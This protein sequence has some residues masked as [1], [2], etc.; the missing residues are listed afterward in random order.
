MFCTSRKLTKIANMDSVEFSLISGF[1]IALLLI[2]LILSNI[3]KIEETFHIPKYEEVKEV[4]MT[5][6]CLFPVKLDKPELRETRPGTILIFF[7]AG[8][9]LFTLIGYFVH[10]AIVNKV[11]Y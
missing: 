6:T 9:L 2:P 1:I 7:V 3:E 5:A 10:C 11:Y 8:V 4:C